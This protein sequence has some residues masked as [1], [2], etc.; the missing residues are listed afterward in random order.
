MR[1]ELALRGHR[2]RIMGFVSVEALR[3]HQ[4]ASGI[5][6]GHASGLNSARLTAQLAPSLK[7]SEVSD[8]RVGI[9]RAAAIGAA[10]I[11]VATAFTGCADLSPIDR[12][13]KD[14]RAQLNQVS[15]EVVAMNASLDKATE[16]SRQAKEAADNAASTANQAL[17]I[18][19]SAQRSVRATN[20][21]LENLSPDHPLK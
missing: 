14:I 3:F 21:R 6:V 12:E 20:E 7:D 5:L 4:G 15:S 1:A 10:M 8:M 16:A 11:L 2:K 19:L 13:F 17:A 18:A 9:G